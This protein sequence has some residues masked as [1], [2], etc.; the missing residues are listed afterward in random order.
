[1]KCAR[2]ILVCLP[3]IFALA[4]PARA[5]QL[6]KVQTSDPAAARAILAA[7][8]RLVA[9]YGGYKLFE[10]AQTNSLQVRDNYNWI[11]LNAGA[12]DTST[13]DAR[14]LRRRQGAFS[15]RRL[16]LVQFA[17]PVQ[18]GWRQTLLETG[19]RIVNYIPQNAYLIYGDAAAL[20]RVQSL[21][22]PAIQ[23]DGPYADS[24]KTHPAARAWKTNLFAIQLVED[25]AANVETLDLL[26]PVAS[27]R[28]FLRFVNV[29]ARLGPAELERVAARPDVVSIQP[30]LRAQKQDERQDQIVAGN[31]FGSGPMGPGYLAWLAG[32][33]FTQEQFDASGFVVD[34][35]DSGID[36]GTTSPNHFGLYA[37][38]DT[39]GA[40]RVVYARLEGTPNSPSTLA[41]CDGH[42]T[43]NAHVV[44]GY[45]NGTGFPFAD[46]AGYAYGLGV[47]PFVRLGSS[48]IF[49]PDDWTSPDFTQL[50]SRAYHDDARISNNSWGYSGADGVYGMASQEFDAL[51]RDAQPEGSS[52]ATPGNQEMVIVF[53][54]GD[55]TNSGSVLEPGTAK[56][57]ITVG[58]ADN[59]QPFGGADRCGVGDNEA[60]SANDMASFSSRGPC[61]DGRRKPDLVAP[62]THVSGGV[63]QAADAGALGTADPC[64][65]G[66]G[67]CGGIGS[68]F[69]P[70]GQQFYTASSG[71]SHS[72]PCVAGAAALLRQYLLNLSFA[73]PSPGH[74][75]G[76]SDERRP[77]PHRRG[78]QRHACGPMPRAWANWTWAR[79]LTARRAFCATNCPATLSPPAAKTR[80]FSGSVADTNLAFRVTLAWT[81]AP[82]NTTGSAYNND[83]DL[84]V[85]AGGQTYLGNVFSGAWSAPGGAAD[86]ADNVES[87]FLPAGCGGRVH[88]HRHRHEHQLRRRAQ[89]QQ[90]ADPGLRAG[91]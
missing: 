84:T 51:V 37:H 54:A 47:C 81:D 20:A 43:L 56:N 45:D 73:P 69:F 9:D 71:T 50:E 11:L 30:C 21:A 10:T 77:L 7:G 32:K 22:L 38:G 72:A 90:R 27:P 68:I 4:G 39:N 42:G 40:S 58:G 1:M 59:V 63:I 14:A 64:Y 74:D 62:C 28:R 31:L 76:L 33:G 55:S 17:G 12:L 48:V 88:R 80:V 49:D 67:V 57:V 26:S 78:R 16:H 44:G 41:G 36:D 87:V 75:Q 65:I 35:S 53:A 52:Y 5:D 86:P 46:G 91:H 70:P 23:W 83:L 29:M 85:K 19:A 2:R 8:G 24:Y 3:A 61:A 34:V 25:G 6:H 89:R 79:R 66:D 60:E 18:P 82:G 15:G 13:P